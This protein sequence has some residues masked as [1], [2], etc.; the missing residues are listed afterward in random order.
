MTAGAKVGD[1]VGSSSSVL[2]SSLALQSPFEMT[3]TSTCCNASAKSEIS[4]LICVAPHPITVAGSST[5]GA[6][7]SECSL[8]NA[9]SIGNRAVKEHQHEIN[10][11]S[12]SIV[13]GMWFLVLHLHDIAITIFQIMSANHHV[14]L[15]T[16]DNSPP[17]VIECNKR[18]T[19]AYEYRSSLASDPRMISF[20]G[21]CGEINV[22]RDAMAG[23]S[24]CCG[25]F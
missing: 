8:T 2:F 17:S 18:S 14:V 25:L 22:L 24:D 11:S 10:A 15:S 7:A 9:I 12:R 1:N 16:P 5:S 3:F 4:S 20:D 21:D 13:I 23:G 6:D 19:T